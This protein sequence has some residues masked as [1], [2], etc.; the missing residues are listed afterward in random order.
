MKDT[1]LKPCPFCG[2]EAYWRLS[3]KK[4]CQLHGDSYQDHIVGCFKP[5]CDIQPSIL[6]CNKEALKES[7]NKRSNNG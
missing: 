5:R 7:W 1:S 6:G 2:G 4:Y 3:K